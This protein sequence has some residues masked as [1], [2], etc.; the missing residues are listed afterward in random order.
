[1]LL[2]LAKSVPK[3]TLRALNIINVGICL[4]TWAVRTMEETH[5]YN[6]REATVTPREE[7]SSLCHQRGLPK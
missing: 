2:F 5:P 7:V 4:S 6:D 1:M 3:V